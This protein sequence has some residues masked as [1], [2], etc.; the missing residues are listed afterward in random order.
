[1]D[2]KRKITDIKIEIM[3]QIKTMD[4]R[5]NKEEIMEKEIEI[6]NVDFLY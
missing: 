5:I 4:F 6:I 3:D 2:F 1:M